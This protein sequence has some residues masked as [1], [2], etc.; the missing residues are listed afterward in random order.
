MSLPNHIPKALTCSILPHQIP[1]ETRHVSEDLFGTEARVGP[2]WDGWDQGGDL[3][4]AGL[5]RGERRRPD[6]K[7][8]MF[9]WNRDVKTA[10]PILQR[11]HHLAVSVEELSIPNA[12]QHDLLPH[13][14]GAADHVIR[15]EVRLV[16]KHRHDA[17]SGRHVAPSA[18][19][20]RIIVI[21]ENAHGGREPRLLRRDGISNSTLPIVG[22]ALEDGHQRLVKLRQVQEGPLE[23]ISQSTDWLAR[24]LRRPHLLVARDVLLGERVWHY[25]YLRHV[26]L[27]QR[28]GKI[29][30]LENLVRFLV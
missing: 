26:R 12:P 23:G 8:R 19:L 11:R 27:R 25:I 16:N 24:G 10:T 15:W 6:W 17:L 2:H 7:V 5:L 21:R 29:L 28:P 22:G 3:L 14:F 18:H 4:L 30:R 20:L 1:E 9:Y 13:A